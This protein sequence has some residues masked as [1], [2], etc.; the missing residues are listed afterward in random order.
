LSWGIDDD[1]LHEAFKDFE[2]L[3][4]ARVV[5][6]KHTGRSKGF[7]YVDFADAESCTKAY[8]AMQGQDL[9]GRALNLDYANARPAEATPQA[10]AADRAKRHGDSVSPESD[11]LFVGNLPFDI[12][13]DTVHQ[14]FSEVREVVSVRLPT[15]P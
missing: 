2:G 3:V 13:Q 6:D 12:D 7:G 1:S 5:W 15:D 4:G 11:T 9:Q 8:D 14:F 10:R